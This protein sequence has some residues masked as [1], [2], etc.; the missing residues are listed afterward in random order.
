MEVDCEI[1]GLEEARKVSRMLHL[2][3]REMFWSFSSYFAGLSFSGRVKLGDRIDCFKR[4]VH[5]RLKLTFVGPSTRQ[6]DTGLLKPEISL[7]RTSAFSSANVVPPSVG[8]TPGSLTCF[9]RSLTAQVGGEDMLAVRQLGTDSYHKSKRP[10][11][12]HQDNQNGTSCVIA[13]VP[14]ILKPTRLS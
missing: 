11:M 4:S 7:S 12:G 5:C 6:C 10:T 9:S 8:E 13:S 2:L 1:H 3:L 14:E